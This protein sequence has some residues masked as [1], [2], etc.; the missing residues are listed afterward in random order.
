M[1]TFREEQFVLKSG[2]TIILKSCEPEEASQFLD[3]IAQIARETKHTRQ[4][5]GRKYQLEDVQKYWE[6]ALTSPVQLCLGAFDENRLIGQLTFRVVEHD[7]PW[8]KH[9]GEFGMMILQ[10]YWSQGLGSK[11]LQILDKI[12]KNTHIHRLEARVRSTN[13]RGLD[14]Y[15][16]HGFEIEGIRQKAALI[17]GQYKNEFYISKMIMDASN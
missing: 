12:A 16:R 6:N 15:L 17:D 9:I 2:K 10:G 14:L 7:H 1:T 5:E 4:Y 13:Y 8:E 3:F 11:M